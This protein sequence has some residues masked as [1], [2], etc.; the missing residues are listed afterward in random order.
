MKD[1]N[2]SDI[3]N[4]YCRTLTLF[5]EGSPDRLKG[6]VEDFLDA[7]R[8]TAVELAKQRIMQYWDG[9][10]WIYSADQPD[11]DTGG[12]IGTALI[13]FLDELVYGALNARGLPSDVR[14]MTGTPVVDAVAFECF[15]AKYEASL[16]K[17]DGARPECKP[18]AREL[19]SFIENFKFPRWW[20]EQ[21]RMEYRLQILEDSDTLAGGNLNAATRA[22]IRD[23]VISPLL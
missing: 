18:L 23:E 21:D 4:V 2:N 16:P 9:D 12:K 13:N 5:D 11:V 20:N 3:T 15:L 10:S 8:D 14:L 17:Y 22:Q 7:S 19:I 1:V 6:T